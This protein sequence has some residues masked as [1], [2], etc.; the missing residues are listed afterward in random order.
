[1]NPNDPM[2]AT[3]FCD[4]GFSQVF[5]N[6]CRPVLS[7]PQAPLSSVGINTGAGYI[8]YATGQPISLSSVHWLWNNQYEAIARNNPFPGVGRNILR[9]DSFNNLDLTVGKSIKLTERISASLQV[10]A[11][12]ALNR[13]YYG[14]PDANIEDTLYP[15]FYGIPN[16]F[17][18]NYYQGGGGESPSAGGAFGQGPGNRSIQLAGKIVF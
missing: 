14:T 5:G 15:A 10:S 2:A 12:N 1:M 6:S 18:T 13:G 7:N 11:F 16:S 9:G 3:S 17:L 8:N 4:F